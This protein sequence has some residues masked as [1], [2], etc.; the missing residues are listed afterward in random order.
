MPDSGDCLI[1][2]S[3]FI[4]NSNVFKINLFLLINPL[5]HIMQI[6]TF[7]AREPQCAHK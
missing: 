5:C 2:V 7:T 4:I 3:H 1:D 6:R